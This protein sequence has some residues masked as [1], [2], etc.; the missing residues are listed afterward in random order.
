M[1]CLDTDES[2]STASLSSKQFSSS[3]CS[4]FVLLGGATPGGALLPI[5]VLCSGFTPHNAQGTETTLQSSP[6]E[7]TL[8]LSSPSANFS[9]TQEEGIL[10]R[11]NRAYE[12][13]CPSISSFLCV[14]TALLQRSRLFTSCFVL[15]HLP[16]LPPASF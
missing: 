6:Q 16:P 3:L 1:L 7:S 13:R 8:L 9:A 12:P 4:F 2:S 11:A 15:K 14:S 10:R 5:L